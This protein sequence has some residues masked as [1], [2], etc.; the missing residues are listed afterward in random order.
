MI[1]IVAPYSGDML[2]IVALLATANSLIPSPTC[3]THPLVIILKLKMY[4]D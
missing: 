1:A 4:K 3:K 2:A